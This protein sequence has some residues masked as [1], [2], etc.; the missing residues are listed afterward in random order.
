MPRVPREGLELGGENLFAVAYPTNTALLIPHRL[1][2]HCPELADDMQHP[3]Q[4]VVGGPGRNHQRTDQPRM[5]GYPDDRPQLP[6][7]PEPPPR[8][9]HPAA[10]NPTGP[11][12]QA[13]TRCAGPG[14]EAQTTAAAEQS[15]PAT[16]SF[17][18]P[19]RS[20]LRSPSPAYLAHPSTISGSQTP[21]HPRSNPAVS[22]HTGT[23]YLNATQ[24]A[25]CSSPP[26]ICGQS[27]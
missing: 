5:A 15:D 10:T 8:S 2:G 17:P 19:S 22:A 7:L 26:P 12:H 27:S 6:H 25:P 16:P 11:T 4:D 18:A 3:R 23:A 1:A 13:G 20:A 21:P 24:P 9:A 14:P